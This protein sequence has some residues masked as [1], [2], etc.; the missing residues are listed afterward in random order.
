[1]L[2]AALDTEL[3]AAD[4]ALSDVALA[5][6]LAATLEVGACAVLLLCAATLAARSTAPQKTHHRIGVGLLVSTCHVVVSR[7]LMA[8][9]PASFDSVSTASDATLD[10]WDVDAGEDAFQD[11]EDTDAIPLHSL[12]DRNGSLLHLRPTGRARWLGWLPHDPEH[13]LTF[14]GVLFLLFLCV[15][16]LPWLA[17]K[18][19]VPTRAP[20]PTAPA[21][22]SQPSSGWGP[23]IGAPASTSPLPPA[24]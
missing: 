17:G 24:R 22:A 14:F 1:M 10:E 21:N 4:V 5:C 9:R 16:L 7:P 8:Q 18:S 19:T 3:G 2:L 6:E 12:R 15:A 13:L 11:L 23:S 20:G